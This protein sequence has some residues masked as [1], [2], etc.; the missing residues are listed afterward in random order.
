MQTGTVGSTTKNRYL[1]KIVVFISPNG[2]SATRNRYKKAGSR[3][4]IA[5]KKDLKSFL[6][7]LK[8]LQY[9][10]SHILIWER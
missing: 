7:L 5:L 2:H 9:F 4:V 10:V 1:L 6:C 3:R 8:K